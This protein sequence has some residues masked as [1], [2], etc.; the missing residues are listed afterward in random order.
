MGLKFTHV[1]LAPAVHREIPID[2]ASLGVTTTSLVD[3]SQKTSP[4]GIFQRGQGLNQLLALMDRGHGNPPF[5]LSYSIISIKQP[6]SSEKC[7][8][9]GI[10]LKI[11][12][13]FEV[14]GQRLP[15]LA[16]TLLA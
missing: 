13:Q 6:L 5:I 14:V 1:G 15:E 2:V 7:R 16:S 3:V 9:F 4:Q 8:V 10:F 12:L 11:F